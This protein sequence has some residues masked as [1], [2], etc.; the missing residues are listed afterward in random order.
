MIERDVV[1]VPAG[2]ARGQTL[3]MAGAVVESRGT[4]TARF[5]LVCMI[6]ISLSHGSSLL[7]QECVEDQGRRIWLPIIFRCYSQHAASVI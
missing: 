4:T 7:R 5:S 6:A 2:C 1:G 3:K